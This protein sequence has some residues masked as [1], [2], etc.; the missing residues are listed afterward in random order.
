MLMIKSVK[1]NHTTCMGPVKSFVTV[2]SLGT[3]H[4]RIDST[5]LQLFGPWVLLHSTLSCSPSL[6]WED[7]RVQASLHI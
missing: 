7:D 1:C 5:Q 2:T 3:L 6:P 4:E